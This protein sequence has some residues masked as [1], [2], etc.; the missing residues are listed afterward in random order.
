MVVRA[1]LEDVRETRVFVSTNVKVLNVLYE[2][3]YDPTGE[4][5]D[6]YFKFDGLVSNEF[7]VITTIHA[8]DRSRYYVNEEIVTLKTKLHCKLLMLGPR[9]VEFQEVPAPLIL[10]SVS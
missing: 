2:A 7:A 4:T 9:S 8:F 6:T 1:Y 5:G 3:K 10:F